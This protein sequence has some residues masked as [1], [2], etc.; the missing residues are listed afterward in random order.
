LQTA[1]SVWTLSIGPEDPSLMDIHSR[2][3]VRCHGLLST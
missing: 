2:V 1:L 3:K